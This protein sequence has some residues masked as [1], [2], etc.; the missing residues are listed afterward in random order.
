MERFLPTLLAL[1]LGGS[2]IA[3]VIFL[4]PKKLPKSLSYYAWLLVLLR[5]ALPIPGPLEFSLPQREATVADF[6]P[7]AVY[8][9]VETPEAPAQLPVAEAEP[10]APIPAPAPAVDTPSPAPEISA[11]QTVE[12]PWGANQWLTLVWVL[13]FLFCLGRE[14]MGYFRFRYHVEKSLMPPTDA[15]LAVFRKLSGPRHPE[16]RRC[17]SLDTPMLMGILRPTLLLPNREYA[18]ETL[19]CILRHELTH[20]QR[21]DIA[22]KWFAMPVLA[23]H[24][25]NPMTYFIRKEID[26]SCELSCDERLL[27]K[28]DHDQRKRYGETLLVLAARSAPAQTKLSTSFA[29]EKKNLKERLVQIMNFSPKTRKTALIAALLLIALAIGCFLFGPEAAPKKEGDAWVVKNVNQLLKVIDSDTKIILEPGVYDLT[30]ARGYG[31]TETEHYRWEDMFDGYQLIIRDVENLTLIGRDTGNCEIVTTPRYAAVLGFERCDGI[32]LSDLTA[33]HTEGPGDCVGAVVT[34]Q[35][36]QNMTVQNAILYGCGTRGVDGFDCDN[37][38]VVNC[39]I[40][41]CSLGGTYFMGCDNVQV[42]ECKVFDCGREELNAYDLFYFNQCRNGIV[43]NCKIT[44]NQADRM[45]MTQTCQSIW[46]VGNQVHGNELNSLFRVNGTAPMVAESSF[47]PIPE[48][49]VYSEFDGI[50]YVVSPDGG[51]LTAKDLKAMRYA[52]SDFVMPKYEA[53][54]RPD[55][56]AAPVETKVVEVSTVDE[57]LAAIAPNTTVLMA[58]GTYDLSPLSDSSEEVSDYY[59]WNREHDGFELQF[60]DLDNFHIQG[61]GKGKTIFTTAPRYADVLW[62]TDCNNISITGITAGHTVEPGQCIGG[63]LNF[64]FCQGVRLDDCGLYGCGI[65]G[66]IADESRDFEVTNTEI[67]ECSQGAV[68]LFHCEN[69]RFDNCDIHDCPE[70]HYGGLGMCKNITVDGELISEE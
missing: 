25:F 45:M 48:A 17:A 66:I 32:T 37:V 62:F 52:K 47:D 44:N 28:M 26:R 34:M 50:D 18:P 30:K 29:T 15:D 1:S 46:F 16:L 5:L 33:G 42:R 13:G 49:F 70:P 3:G 6:Q 8:Q 61:A 63:V 54:V 2:V 68:E 41:E 39:N 23:A 21:R 12:I 64:H 22:Y 53:P 24:W 20:Y 59:T 57:F 55:P 36:S 9:E 43:Q 60:R 65:L 35:D 51:K 56:E 38:E 69:M 4:L 10:Q 27:A 40:T 11:P 31:K 67:Y 7:S 19:E 58:E 14:L